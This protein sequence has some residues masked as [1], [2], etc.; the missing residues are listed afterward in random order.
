MLPQIGLWPL[1]HPSV[2]LVLVVMTFC[3]VSGFAQSLPERF[4]P[5]SIRVTGEATVTANPDQAKID[6]GVV[7][8]AEKAETASAQNATRVDAVL[9]ALKKT[10]GQRAEIKTL[11]YSVSPNYRYPKEGG[12]PT[13]TGYTATNVLQVT[14]NELSLIGKVIDTAVQFGANSIQRLQFTLK[15]DSAVQAEAL[16]EASAKAKTKAQTIASALGVNIVQILE[17]D[18]TVSGAVPRVF[19]LAEARAAG[20]AAPTPMEPGGITVRATVT[21][22]VGIGQ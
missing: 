15:D 3:S 21:L 5:P 13:I 17:A 19:A 12:A 1:A 9:A 20:A 18:E 10:L 6:V 8:Q 16:R 14:L 11:S 22:T 4:R 7:T 2:V